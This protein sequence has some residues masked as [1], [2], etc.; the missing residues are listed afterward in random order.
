MSRD[1]IWTLATWSSQ[2]T[3]SLQHVTSQAWLL[4]FRSI[5][6]I[7][8]LLSKHALVYYIILYYILKNCQSGSQG[9]LC[10]R[11][12][13]TASHDTICLPWS[14]FR[15]GNRY[16]GD[17]VVKLCTWWCSSWY[18][19][20]VFNRFCWTVELRLRLHDAIYRLRFYSKLLIALKLRQ[21]KL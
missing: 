7:G 6:G 19:S 5:A 1:I 20:F 3:T 17:E 12:K 4:L 9:H 8:D 11:S 2:P 14:L 18:A 13:W 15:K 21:R 16:P 10:S